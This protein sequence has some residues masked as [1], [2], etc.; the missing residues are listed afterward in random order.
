MM[1]AVVDDPCIALLGQHG[2]P[3]AHLTAMLN[4]IHP[5]HVVASMTEVEAIEPHPVCVVIDMPPTVGSC[6]FTPYLVKPT[7][8]PLVFA[9]DQRADGETLE[10]QLRTAKAHNAVNYIVKPAGREAIR[11]VLSTCRG[12]ACELQLASE[13]QTS[14]RG[15]AAATSVLSAIMSV[16]ARSLRLEDVTLYEEPILEALRIG[17]INTWLRIVRR[18]HNAT[19]RHSLLVTGAGVAFAQE[20]G[21]H[22]ED[23]KRIARA[24][25]LHDIG[26]AFISIAILDKPGKLTEAEMDTIRKHPRLGYD[27]LNDQ[28][29]F[30]EEIL[31]CV[32]HHHE[33]LDG[34][35]YPDSLRGGEIRDLVRIVTIADIF[36]ALIERRAYKPPLSS[37]RALEIMQDMKGKLDADLLKAFQPVAL[38]V[39]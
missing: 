17:G 1:T 6:N 8:Y 4:Q 37:A 32:L 38:G 9:V 11:R 14:E 3:D 16:P 36:A 13:R 29:G 35:G 25:L 18:H 10:R 34:S 12:P 15:V 31:D 28:G 23:Q 2:R 26:K 20:L 22:A 30:P 19:Y 27:A 39:H 24:S 21:M 33:F 5:V 7:F